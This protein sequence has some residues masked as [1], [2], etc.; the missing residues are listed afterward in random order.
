MELPES[1][2]NGRFKYLDKPAAAP[3][4]CAVCGAVDRPVIDF[5]FDVDYYG[6]VYICVECMKAANT[7]VD[8]YEDPTAAPV[9]PPLLFLDAEAVNEYVTRATVSVTALNAV[10]APIIGSMVDAEAT[11]ESNGVSDETERSVKPNIEQGSTIPV[12]KGPSSVPADSSSDV[13]DL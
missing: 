9:V 3:G 2:V 7:V 10:L 8:L 1:V 5:G 13:F 12:S 11:E 6:A 4:K